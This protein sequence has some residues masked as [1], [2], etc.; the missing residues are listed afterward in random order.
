[1]PNTVSTSMASSDMTRLWA[2]VTSIGVRAR[3]CC[4]TC[5]GL[6]ALWPPEPAGALWPP[7]PAGALWPMGTTG[8]AGLV[9]LTAVHRTLGLAACSRPPSVHKKT[10]QSRG[11]RRRERV[12]LIGQTRREST[13][14]RATPELSPGA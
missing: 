9:S 6:G 13:R 14:T 12:Y 10:L 1:M 3:A 7:E 2:P 5:A 8:F 11:G 4:A